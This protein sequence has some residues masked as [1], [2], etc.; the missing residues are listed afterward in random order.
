MIDASQLNRIAQSVPILQ[1]ANTSF[2]R[3]FQQAAFFA[4]IPAG[5]DVFLEGDRVE[6]IALLISGVVRVY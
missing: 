3:E 6:E 2:V 4:R 5:H 1:Q